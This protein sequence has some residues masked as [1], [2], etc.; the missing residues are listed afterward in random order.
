MNEVKVNRTEG[1]NK[2]SAE[3]GLQYPTFHKDRATRQKINKEIG[4][5]ETHYEL[6]APY[7]AL[8]PITEYTFFS[9]TP[10]K[11]SCLRPS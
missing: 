8:H 11:F 5:L 9:I 2:I 7:R 6:T 1:R 10:E 3:W 4:D